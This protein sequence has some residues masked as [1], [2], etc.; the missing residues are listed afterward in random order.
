MTGMSFKKIKELQKKF[1]RDLALKK[2]Q[3]FALK[4]KFMP[5]KNANGQKSLNS[6]ENKDTGCFCRH[7]RRRH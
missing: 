3:L 1:W 7:Y 6:Q 5:A 4:L 2:T